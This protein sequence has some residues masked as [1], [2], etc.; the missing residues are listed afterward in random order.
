MSRTILPVHHHTHSDMPL[1]EDAYPHETHT[2]T[3][4]QTEPIDYLPH[5]LAA[6]QTICQQKLVIL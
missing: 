1:S 3:A 2:N 5:I 4:T 6:I